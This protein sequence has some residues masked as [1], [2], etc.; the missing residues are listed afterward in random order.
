[1][2]CSTHIHAQQLCKRSTKRKLWSRQRVCDALTLLLF[3]VVGDVAIFFSVFPQGCTYTHIMRYAPK[4]QSI[5][6]SRALHRTV[7]FFDLFM[8]TSI[9]LFASVW[10]RYKIRGDR[11]T[12]HRADRK[13]QVNMSSKKT[14]ITSFC[15]AY[16]QSELSGGEA[17]I[18]WNGLVWENTEHSHRMWCEGWI[19][20]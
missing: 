7:F 18:W 15:V 19:I 12:L 1:M 9:L 16:P 11:K 3:R 4:L 8:H 10:C 13:S 2:C 14:V 6:L 5:S 17:E 20:C